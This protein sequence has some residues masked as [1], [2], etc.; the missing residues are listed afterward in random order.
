[1]PNPNSK[2][3]QPTEA[4]SAHAGWLTR[5]QVAAEP[6]YRSIFPIRR[7]LERLHRALRLAE[8][9]RC[10]DVRHVAGADS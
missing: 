8:R 10:R 3:K 6:G 4:T 5:A 9:H 2:P 1:M 7:V